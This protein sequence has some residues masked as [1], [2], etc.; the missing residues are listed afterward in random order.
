MYPLSDRRAGRLFQKTSPRVFSSMFKNI[1]FPYT[2]LVLL[3]VGESMG[4]YP[5][6]LLLW[7]WRALLPKLFLRM[8]DKE[9]Q[10]ESPK[11]QP[12][13]LIGFESCL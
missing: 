13:M 11:S 3:C 2:N 12:H 9:G 10:K 4:L 6:K 8:V 7:S 5:S 1:F